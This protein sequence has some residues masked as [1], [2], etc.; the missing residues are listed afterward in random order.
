MSDCDSV[1]FENENLN[2][3]MERKGS[4]TPMMKDG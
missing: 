3:K 4:H 1:D 2:Y